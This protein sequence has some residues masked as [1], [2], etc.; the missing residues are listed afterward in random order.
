MRVA[1][2][3]GALSRSNCVGIVIEAAGLSVIEYGLFLSGL[4]AAIV[5]DKTISQARRMDW[6]EADWIPCCIRMPHPHSFQNSSCFS[7]DRTTY[8]RKSKPESTEM[9]LW[10]GQFHWW[11]RKLRFRNLNLDDEQR[12]LRRLVWQRARPLSLATKIG[13]VSKKTPDQPPRNDKRGGLKTPD[14]PLPN[15]KGVVW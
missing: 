12:L 5:I 1:L 6:R 9:F 11:R 14:Q 8:S 10:E 4:Q 2:G 3:E 13:V 7:S 15:D